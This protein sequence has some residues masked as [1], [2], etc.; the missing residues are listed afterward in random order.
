MKYNF[1]KSSIIRLIVLTMIVLP[2][3]FCQ[4]RRNNS[5]VLKVKDT[6]LHTL[7]TELR[8]LYDLSQLPS[9]LEDTKNAQIS[10]Y[11]TTW[12]NDDGFS[13]KYSYLRKNSDGSLVLFDVKGSGVINRIWTPTPNEDTLDFFIDDTLKTSF[14]ICYMDLF[15]GKKYPF[16][17]PLCGNQLGGYYCYLPIPFSSSCRIQSRGKLEQFHQIGYRL[18]KPGSGAKPF[19]ILLNDEERKELDKISSLWGKSTRSVH[20]FYPE[21]IKLKETGIDLLPGKTGIVFEKKGG[22]RIL[23]IEITPASAFAGMKKNTDI[24]ITWDGEIKPAVYCPAGDFFGFAFGASAMQSLLLGTKTDTAYSYIPMPFDRSARIELINRESEKSSGSRNIKVRVWYSDEKRNTSGEGKFYATWQKE[25]PV[26]DGEPHTIADIHGKGHFIGTL[27]QAQ[28][29]KTGMT[30]FF[31]GDDSLSIDGNFRMHGT[32]SED[33]FNGGWYAMMDRW[34]DKMS[35]PLHGCLGYSLPFCRTGG[36]RFYISDKLSFSKSLFLS[37]EHGPVGN[38]FPADYS[39]LGLYYSDTPDVNNVL[40][41]A[42]NTTVFIPDTLYIYPQLI[43]FTIYGKVNIETTWKYGT[44]GES[45]L[46]TPGTDSWIRMSLRDIPAGSYSIY[47]DILGSPEGCEF[48]LWHRQKRLSEW[49]SSFRG[50]D[51]REPFVHACDFT[52]P[53]ANKSISVRFRQDKEKQKFL[54]NRVIFIKN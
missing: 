33:Y 26:K 47:F 30:I 27:L 37:I 25:S 39:S 7:T 23:G 54:L 32:G 36:Y 40:P 38:R 8:A 3:F 52:V 2:L 10:T 16:I 45:Y 41:K 53:E 22:G 28:G 34:D 15:S 42:E 18:Y 17:A 24:R 50:Q 13:G 21:N 12:G 11:D 14:S 9:Y 49:I 43:E 19:N 5:P 20:D 31:E 1:L 6:C 29:L 4:C 44:G 35:L 51:L 48:S 46:F